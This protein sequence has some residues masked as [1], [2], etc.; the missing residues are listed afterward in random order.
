MFPWDDIAAAMP[1]EDAERVKQSG[2]GLLVPKATA[3]L[4]QPS[5]ARD[6]SVSTASGAKGGCISSE[7]RDG[8]IRARVEQD[9][10]EVISKEMGSVSRCVELRLPRPGK[11]VVVRDGVAYVSLSP[12]G[13]AIIDLKDPSEPHYDRTEEIDTAIGSMRDV[14][15]TLW[16]VQA[17]NAIVKRDLRNL[18]PSRQRAPSTEE[19][20]RPS[21]VDAIPPSPSSEVSLDSRLRGRSVGLRDGSKVRGQLVELALLRHPPHEFACSVGSGLM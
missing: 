10:L 3:R 1:A 21:T 4:N 16:I 7:T 2:S 17:N 13:L 9:T 6:A 15:G 19:R 14:D 18:Q 20:F 5:T 8:V 12:T 11:T